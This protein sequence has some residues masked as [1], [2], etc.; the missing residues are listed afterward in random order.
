MIKKSQRRDEAWADEWRIQVLS[1][2]VAG[3]LDEKAKGEFAGDLLAGFK[4]HVLTTADSYW[5]NKLIPFPRVGISGRQSKSEDYVETE[6]GDLVGATLQYIS[7]HIVEFAASR[8]S[9]QVSVTQALF[10]RIPSKPQ[11]NSRPCSSR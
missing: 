6:V 8:E 7:H 2:L 1:A 9:L 5:S 4:E 10:L 11:T 3:T